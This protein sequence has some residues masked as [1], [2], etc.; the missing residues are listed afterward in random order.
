MD[1]R[2]DYRLERWIAAIL[3]LLFF[4]PF[5]A[6]ADEILYTELFHGDEVKARN[7]EDFLALVQDSNS[8]WLLQPVKI[9]VTTEYDPVVDADDEQTGKRV[10]VAGFD[11]VYLLR[12]RKLHAGVV[13]AATPPSAE[14]LPV[15][16]PQT[17]V[18]GSTRYVLHYR[19][20]GAPDPDGLVDCMLV[21]ESGG[22]TQVLAKFPALDDDGKLAPMDIEHS[23]IFAGDLDHD[24]KLDLVANVSSHWNETRSAL[25]LSS[26]A[27]EGDLV[28]RVAELV[29][30]GC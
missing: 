16:K 17:I 5:V 20:A 3:F 18:L 29:A 11:H 14:L 25:F 10:A 22:I 8:R 9:R 19:C 21:L 4:L 6:N 30:T 7:G 13:T 2:T 23:V 28:A 26:A 1:Q 15:S 12:G 27:Q 24:G